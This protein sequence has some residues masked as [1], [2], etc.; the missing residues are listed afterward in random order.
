MADNELV[1]GRLHADAVGDLGPLLE[2]S[3]YKPLRFLA[4]EL[5]GDLVEHWS[6][7]LRE[8]LATDQAH[9]FRATLGG[10]TVGMI[11]YS[12]SPWDTRVMGEKA[13]GLS[14]F[15]VAYAAP[16]KR[17]IALLLLDEALGLAR[18]QGVRF[19]SS[20]TYTDDV[21]AIHALESRGFLL[22]DTVVDC[23]Y[24]F[25]KAPPAADAAPGVSAGVVLRAARPED[26]AELVS[27][28]NL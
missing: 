10:E 23:Y 8:L 12:D 5:G 13:A 16:E 27:V 2:A 18:S 28:A 17:R 19:L 21:V 25:R 9:G 26:R 11:I 20:K 7:T 22:M 6:E 15:V 24:D 14:H 3:P 1:I 4:R